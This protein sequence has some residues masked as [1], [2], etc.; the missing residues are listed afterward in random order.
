MALRDRVLGIDFGS[1][2]IGLAMS[3]PLFI[4]AHPLQAIHVVAGNLQAAVR[5]IAS[6]AREH[7]VKLAVVGLPLN[8]DDSEG[9]QSKVTRDFA[10]LLEAESGLTV[11]LEDERLTSMAAEEILRETATS[12]KRRKKARRSGK[13][14]VVAAQVLLQAWMDRTQREEAALARENEVPDE[15]EPDEEDEDE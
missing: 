8:M 9:P 14:D 1:K 15:G 3:D 12:P 5:E 2:R 10:A 4:A 11:L 7:G 6:L 13:V